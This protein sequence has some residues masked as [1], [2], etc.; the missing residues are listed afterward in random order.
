MTHLLDGNVLI[1]L[2]VADHVHHAAAVRWWSSGTDEVAT[3]PTTQGALL[4]LL[5]RGGLGSNLSVGVLAALTE[6]PRHRFWPAD[7]GY[8]AVDMSR[9]L[10]HGQVT[11]AYLAA[12]ARRRGARLATFD[13]GL[14]QQADDVVTLLPA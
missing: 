2:T 8:D 10:G 6:H 12:L 5:I 14:A 13:R 3:C 4:R 11:D 7:I 1:A 9:V